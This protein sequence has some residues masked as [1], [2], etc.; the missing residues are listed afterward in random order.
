VQDGDKGTGPREGKGLVHSHHDV[1]HR[2]GTSNCKLTALPGTPQGIQVA[3]QGRER[4]DER[5]GEGRERCE[6]RGK[7]GRRRKG[8][9]RGSSFYSVASLSLDSTCLL[10]KVLSLAHGILVAT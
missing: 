7:E 8:G 1:F 4:K 6:E 3:L 5:G 9:K 2:S 10:W